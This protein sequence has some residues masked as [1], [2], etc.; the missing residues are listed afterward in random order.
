MSRSL[1]IFGKRLTTSPVPWI[2]LSCDFAVF[3]R[4]LP[5]T[6]PSPQPHLSLHHHHLSNH[7]TATITTIVMP[8]PHYYHHSD[9]HH[10]K[11]IT[12]H[13]T[14]IASPHPTTSIQSQPP[15]DTNTFPC[16]ASLPSLL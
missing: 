15:A 14:T 1:L 16:H 8:P 13:D 7:N 11:P 12:T 6:T 4:A 9:H 5:F 10:Y 3:H 2:L